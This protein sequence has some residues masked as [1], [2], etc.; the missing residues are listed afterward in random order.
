MQNFYWGSDNPVACQEFDDWLAKTGI[1]LE[2]MPNIERH[3]S[4]KLAAYQPLPKRIKEEYYRRSVQHYR[5]N[6][7]R[8]QSKPVTA[9]LMVKLNGIMKS[10]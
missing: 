2:N 7:T 8:K 1:D 9:A 5:G 4:S 10:P 3:V 6:F